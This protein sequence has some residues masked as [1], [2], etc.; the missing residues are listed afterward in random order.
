MRATALIVALLLFSSAAVEAETMQE[1]SDSIF[2]ELTD[3]TAFI[4]GSRADSTTAAVDFNLWFDAASFPSGI[5]TVIECN[6]HYADPL[7]VDSIILNDATWKGTL[8]VD[9]AAN[10]RKMYFQGG[11][12]SVQYSRT[13]YAKIYLHSG[14][15]LENTEVSLDLVKH[16]DS[17][18][19]YVS[20]YGF[21]LDTNCT[22][23]YTDGSVTTE[24]YDAEFEFDDVEA[25]GDTGTEVVVPLRLQSNFR[26]SKIEHY[27]AFDTEKLEF[28]GLVEPDPAVFADGCS[29]CPDSGD[30]PIILTLDADIDSCLV[31]VEP[32]AD[33]DTIYSLRFRVVS[34]PQ[35]DDDTTKIWFIPDN[36]ELYS[37][38]TAS[39]PP[40]CDLLDTNNTYNYDTAL[41][42]L[43]GYPITLDSNLWFALGDDTAF[44]ATTTGDTTL[45]EAW[46]DLEYTF[47]AL[48]GT[49]P[50]GYVDTIQ[51]ELTFPPGGNFGLDY[52]TIVLEDWSGDVAVTEVE[53]GHYRLVFSDDTEANEPPD[54]SM[55]TLGRLLFKLGCAFSEDSKTVKFGDVIDQCWVVVDSAK[56]GPTDSSVCRDDG[57]VTWAKYEAHYDFADLTLDSTYGS[58]FILPVTGSCNFR[59]QEL[60]HYVTYQSNKLEFVELI[61]NESVFPYG[62]ELCPDSSDNPIIFRLWPSAYPWYTPTPPLD[63]DTIYRL[64]F[65][66]KADTLWD[67]TTTYVE[68]NSGN[69]AT[70]VWEDRTGPGQCCPYLTDSYDCDTNGAAIYMEE[71]T[72]EFHCLADANTFYPEGG[73]TVW[74]TLQMKNNFVAGMPAGVDT[75]NA[76]YFKGSITM[77][78]ELFESVDFE[79]AWV[80]HDELAFTGTTPIEDD[81]F[82]LY[83]IW[84]STKNNSVPYADN[85]V[86]V[87]RVK[88]VHNNLEI[89]SFDDR[90]QSLFDFVALATYSTYGDTA[91]VSDTTLVDSLPMIRA[92]D[93]NGRL[94]WTVDTLEIGVGEFFCD[95]STGGSG[96]RRDTLKMRH[97]FD[98]NDFS[99]TVKIG[100]DFMIDTVVIL[101]AGV[102]VDTIYRD[103]DT[104]FC[105]ITDDDTT[106]FT[107]DTSKYAIAEITYVLDRSCP[108]D[109]GYGDTVVFEDYSM[110]DT[111]DT[112]HYVVVSEN[113]V[114]H[115][116]CQSCPPPSCPVL[117]SWDGEGF[118]RDNPLLT[119][120]EATGYTEVVTDH[121][122]VNT[123]VAVADG[124]ARFQLLELEDEITYLE[125]LTLITVD[126]SSD[127]R[128]A[129]AANGTINTYSDVIEPLSAVDHNGV[130][131]LEA[132]ISRDGL[133]FV[134]EEP[135]YLIVTFP[136]GAGKGD[137]YSLITGPGKGGDI[138]PQKVG[139]DSDRPLTS[140][141]VETLDANGQ[142]VA[143]EEALPPR[144]NP[145]NEVI[146]INLPLTSGQDVITQR[147][148]W[149][150]RYTTDAVN[151]F[152]ASDE[153]PMIT[154][155]QVSDYAVRYADAAGKAWPGFESGETLVMVR[156]D[157]LDFSFECGT[158]EDPEIVRDY[159]IVA[160][161][162]YEPDYSVYTHLIPGRFQL[163][164]AY[165]NPFNPTA[166]IGYDLP[167]GT[168]VK[169]EVYNLLGQRVATLV[170]DYQDAGHHSVEWNSTAESGEAVASGVY[171]YRLTTE[172][173]TESKKMILLK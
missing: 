58:E 24:D 167:V 56:Y 125:S 48:G 121:Y 112:A 123:P 105:V 61:I 72:A 82:S 96:Y 140:V 146:P 80:I 19:V 81:A 88:C 45:E 126:H 170:D 149:T 28:V 21:Y 36:C 1:P 49:P 42:V 164:D 166:T 120:C 143:S 131:R 100:E 13:S 117:F 172:A 95:G 160:V 152:V 57:T 94:T 91:R 150:T 23:C 169:L 171:F 124:A 127:T 30:S 87:L 109:H 67:G 118:A 103:D 6:F 151:Q 78:A 11:E 141:K 18:Y 5:L 133:L 10:V 31:G 26:M 20:G 114:I 98:M 9:S 147:I 39:C 92:T 139:T 17:A 15:N 50:S 129:C 64:R 97:N 25:S 142:W 154:N 74:Y 69:C 84:D 38:Y 68:F 2:F 156:G 27:I 157:A 90:I 51:V 4:Q 137:R 33:S 75:S 16:E 43:Q 12:D 136:T 132:V 44:V 14:C 22:W 111:D 60:K 86:N 110:V 168:D 8:T 159:I 104:S 155:W 108:C 59:T 145:V 138:C 113:Q 3:D 173:F 130:A 128:V 71:R 161:G 32:M 89:E 165:P 76:D 119:A 85:L 7:V 153:Q 101:S 99:V 158:N 115:R 37:W 46:L 83:Q 144:M 35:V 29:D 122:L 52:D 54:D 34:D 135:G 102:V 63:G 106:T 73:D 65:R 41:V 148:S 66:I 162:R 107:E 163:Y 40:N 53:P 93:D 134:S 79:S 116:T 62:C 70:N 55:L 77:N 47:G